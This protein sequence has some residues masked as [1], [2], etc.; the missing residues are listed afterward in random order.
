MAEELYFYGPRRTQF[1]C[2]GTQLAA[3]VRS[4]CMIHGL[5]CRFNTCAW[6]GRGY[7][8]CVPYCNSGHQ[9]LPSSLPRQQHC[10]TNP[11]SS[12]CFF[13]TSCSHWRSWQEKGRNLRRAIRSVKF[14][15]HLLKNNSLQKQVNRLK[16]ASIISYSKS[17]NLIPKTGFLHLN[18]HLASNTKL[19]KSIILFNLLISAL[20]KQSLAADSG[21]LSTFWVDLRAKNPSTL[22]NFL[23]S[24]LLSAN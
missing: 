14:T 8:C 16:S 21:W 12:F 22:R 15:S 23:L 19:I 7:Q 24:L 11:P 20:N 6:W 17:D 18:F 1:M 10:R 9:F 4:C 5:C 13:S 3:H 2:V